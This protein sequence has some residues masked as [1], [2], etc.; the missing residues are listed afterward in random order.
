[1]TTLMLAA[2]HNCAGAAFAR[3]RGALALIPSYGMWNSHTTGRPQ[4]LH[5]GGTG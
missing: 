5:E 1:M 2:K 4:G 3:V